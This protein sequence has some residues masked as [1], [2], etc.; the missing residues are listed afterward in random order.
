MVAIIV[1]FT[2]FPIDSID[3]D[4]IFFAAFK[5]VYT[6]SLKHTYT[7]EAPFLTESKISAILGLCEQKLLINLRHLA[8]DSVDQQHT[9]S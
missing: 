2:D 1:S 8:N 9:E 6:D 3:R 7:F 4:Y 5:K